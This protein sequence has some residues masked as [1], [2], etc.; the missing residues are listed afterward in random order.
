MNRILRLASPLRRRVVTLMGHI[1]AFPRQ[2][3]SRRFGRVHGRE[4]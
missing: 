2:A 4:D 1:P 3:V